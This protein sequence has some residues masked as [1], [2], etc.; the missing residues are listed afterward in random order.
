MG[1]EKGGAKLAG[2]G[3]LPGGDKLENRVG[4]ILALGSK[5]ILK[6]GVWG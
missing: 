4:L 2:I 6:L 3:V 5:L 1:H